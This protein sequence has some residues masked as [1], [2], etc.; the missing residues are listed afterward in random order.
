MAAHFDEGVNLLRHPGNGRVHRI[1]ESL[2]YAAGLIVGEPAR[3]GRALTIV[4]VVL[5][6]QYDE[7]GAAW[8][9]TFPR[10][11]EEPRPQPGAVIWRDYD[12]NWRQFIGCVL[13][14]LLRD[15]PG[16]LGDARCERVRRAVGLALRGEPPR[17]IEPAYSNIALL[18]A[19]L[20]C[21]HGDQPHGEALAR[22]VEALFNTQQG[23]SEYNS[24]TY[25]GVD[26][27]ALALWRGS[28]NVLAAAGRGLEAALWRD[29]AAFYHPGLSNLCGPYDR[30]YGMDMTQY[31]SL[32][33]LWLWWA[34]G[35]RA[36]PDPAITFAHAHDFCAT[37]L[38]ALAPPGIPDDVAMALTE[39]VVRR[40]L[41]RVMPERI[42]TASLLP[43]LMLGAA[44][45]APL[46][47][48]GQA[49]PVTAHWRAA[50]GSIAWLAI[51]SASL[52]AEVSGTTIALRSD[53]ELI[54]ELS[55]AATELGER[56]WTVGGRRIDVRGIELLPDHAIRL[57]SGSGS[58]RFG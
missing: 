11:L 54:L 27:W 2:W 35:V 43:D 26:L 21:Q 8:D 57:R 6:T 18:Q 3:I 50:D 33:G 7:P 30:A 38:L 13:A 40:T 25:Y 41:R 31:A 52:A 24:P 58:L 55:S 10:T 5:A 45:P 16:V 22:D 15:Y 4:D 53:A 46:D 14:I 47:T 34:C 51:R 19:W 28:E 42:V 32:L 56:R 49:R 17:R 20:L 9:G 39:P 1:R 36:F 29:I 44:A 37:P 12:P 23:F 48:T